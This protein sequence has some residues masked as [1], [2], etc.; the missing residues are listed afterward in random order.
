MLRWCTCRD[1][2]DPDM[3]DYEL[4]DESPFPPAA[5]RWARTEA[6]SM[7]AFFVDGA[8]TIREAAASATKI[9]WG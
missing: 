1:D 2:W 8:L 7:R 6:L 3:V 9:L 4:V 5:E